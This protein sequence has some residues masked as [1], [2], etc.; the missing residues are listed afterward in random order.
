MG[1]F[2][3]WCIGVFAVNGGFVCGVGGYLHISY[4]VCLNVHMYI[5]FCFYI[6]LLSYYQY[7]KVEFNLVLS[8]KSLFL[9]CQLFTPRKS[10]YPLSTMKRLW[11]CRVNG[12]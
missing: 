4:C 6:I 1:E 7:S 2:G 5:I 8:P 3:V 9:F 12:R 10:T 11:G